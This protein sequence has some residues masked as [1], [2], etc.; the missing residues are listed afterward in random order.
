MEGFGMQEKQGLVSICNNRAES[1][2]IQ[3]GNTW[4]D[5]IEEWARWLIVQREREII[6]TP[7]E[8][9]ASFQNQNKLMD[10]KRR[11]GWMGS[12]TCMQ[13]AILRMPGFQLSTRIAILSR[14]QFNLWEKSG[15]HKNLY[16][17]F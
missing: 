5:W 14:T 17:C 12:Y 16:V 15:Q 11:G 6:T 9:N 10:D 2:S 13:D 1:L 3:I 7:M 4:C 8:I